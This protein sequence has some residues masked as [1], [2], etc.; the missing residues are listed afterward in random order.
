MDGRGNLE[1]LHEQLKSGR[2]RA[3]PLRRSDIPKEDGRL[4]P[5][6]IP[7]LEDKV[8]QKATGELL[9]AI[10][11]QDFLRCSYGSRPGRSA[12]DALDE[13]GRIIGQR[14]ITYVLEAD[15]GGYF[16]AIVREK[17]ME[18]V[19]RGVGDRSRLRLLRKW[20]NV[21]VIEEGRLLVTKTGTGQGQGISPLLANIYLHYVLDEWFE[22][23]VKPRL[24]GE[25]CEVRYVDDFILCF[26]YREDAERVLAAL[27][28]RFGK[29][30]VDASPR[31]NATDR[32]WAKRFGEVRRA[33]RKEAWDF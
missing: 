24:R 13:I 12:H 11:E 19:E 25:A 6:A 32:V 4:R 21:G 17:L 30:G 1:K 26:Q 7:S 31:E 10:Y 3:Q 14:P 27:K 9:S 16:D 22:R 18:M 28:E 5:M 20:L 15:I 29:Y 33:G 8:V 23:E 2:Y